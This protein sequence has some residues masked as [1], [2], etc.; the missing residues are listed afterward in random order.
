MLTCIIY[1]HI[2]QTCE[3]MATISIKVNVYTIMHSH[4]K[5]AID[6]CGKYKL[7]SCERVP[8]RISN[9][10]N[11]YATSYLSLHTIPAVPCCR[12]LGNWQQRVG[13]CE[14]FQFVCLAV[15]ICMSKY[16]CN[17]VCMLYMCQYS[18]NR[19]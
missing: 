2:P 18:N 1:S 11:R 10:S 9:R 6:V 16:V 4:Q 19:N 13:I 15:I 14:L 5:D 7:V 8:R 17:M 3:D 12:L